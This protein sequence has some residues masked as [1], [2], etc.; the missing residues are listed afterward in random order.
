MLT[1][2]KPR[3]FLLAILFLQFIV[4]VTVFF[5][6]PIARQVIGFIY[7]TFVPGFVILKLLKL[8]ELDGVETLLFSIGLGIA[9]LM[10]TGLFINEFGLIFGF[11]RPLSL[12]PLMIILN[13]LIL[14]GGV[15]V[16]LRSENVKLFR[17]ETFKSSPSALLLMVLPVLSVL[18]AMWV[19]V[20]E[21]NLILLFMI[22]AIAL[23]FGLVAISKSLPPNLYPLCIFVIAISLLYHSS[24]ISN[25]LIHFGSDSLGEYFA[26]KIVEKD[27]YWSSIN[28]YVGDSS[29]GRTYA[30][31]SVTI[32]PLIYS[33]LLNLNSVWT[34]KV[35]FAIFFSFVPLILYK[36][37]SNFLEKKYA[38]IASYFFM[39]FEPFYFEILR[40]NKQIIGELFFCL[41]TFIIINKNL[42]LSDQKKCF[43]IF[44]FGIIISHYALAEILLIFLICFTLAHFIIY[45][46]INKKITINMIIYFST[47]MFFWYLYTSSSSVFESWIN[48]G[49]YVYRQMGDFFNIASRERDVLRGLGLEAPSTIWNAISRA[50]AYLTELFI[51]IGFM[52][53]IMKRFK[54]IRTRINIEVEKSY[55][56]FALISMVFL[57]SLILIPGLS[58][59]MNMTRF[60]HILLFFLAPLCVI[61]AD[62]IVNLV[63]KQRDKFLTSVL[64]IFV[65]LP[66]FLFQTSFIYEVTGS[67]SWSLPLSKYRMD[68]L[69]LYGNLG[70]TDE[71]SISGAQWLS[72]N[73]DVDQTDI[74][75]DFWSRRSELRGYG[76]IYVGNIIT[77]SN[78][79]KIKINGIVYMRSFN[80]IEE[81][82]V[83][84]SYIWNTTDLQFICEL[85]KI[86]SNGGSIVYKNIF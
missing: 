53:L 35:L 5:D 31:L 57:V 73:V 7:L 26:F 8:D 60:Y 36:I 17:T 12:M 72:K 61:G 4:Y 51:I 54:I 63:Y 13:S 24:L 46:Q 66:Y 84:D 68:T 55:F 81:L 86:Y 1:E 3:N 82:V 28:P 25:N 41:L 45:K 76:A 69:R 27:E 14:V 37:W 34:F 20:Y 50:F 75:S 15:L 2:L 59:T 74:Y 18:G 77:L 48:F 16:Y 33:I 85:D 78:M 70:Y 32:L 38:F 21:N 71:Q 44:S 40:L 10:L 29:V 9:F 43:L 6:V 19:N 79:T 58:S 64:L 62:F 67:E 65:L 83:G 42:K 30:M 47:L 22:I 52:G 80:V 56:V 49:D 39:S 23:L 11:S